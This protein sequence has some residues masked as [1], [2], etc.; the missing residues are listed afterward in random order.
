MA[1]DRKPLKEQ[2][3]DLRAGRT[4]ELDGYAIGL[5]FSQYQA[6]ADTL[7]DITS[8][9]SKISLPFMEK[10]GWEMVVN[11]LEGMTGLQSLNISNPS[12]QEIT[13]PDTL[14]NAIRKM[15]KLQQLNL[16]HIPITTD[17]SH[18]LAAAFKYDVKDLRTIML[19][20]VPQDT[21]SATRLLESL[22]NQPQLG[23]AELEDCRLGDEHLDILLD[24]LDSSP[25]LVQLRIRNNHFSETAQEQIARKLM[26]KRNPNLYWTDMD[27]K[28]DELT[29]F[30]S[31]NRERTLNFK[32][33]L[34]TANWDSQNPPPPEDI[35]TYHRLRT[36]LSYHLPGFDHAGFTAMLDRLLP[37]PPAPPKLDYLLAD[38]KGYTALDNPKTWKQYPDLLDKLAEQGELTTDS[39][40]RASPYGVTLLESAIRFDDAG[41]VIKAVNRVGLSIGAELLISEDGKPTRLMQQ[42]IELN[43]CH[44][45]FTEE[46]WTGQSRQNFRTVLNIIPEEQRTAI[47]NRHA[48]GALVS[49]TEQAGRQ[50]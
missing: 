5:S 35:A 47:S 38:Y 6:I 4:S 50:I 27:A 9:V 28:P 37:M 49:A 19:S 18:T 40:K 25:N 29:A 42:L 22:K 20:G 48:I 16:D 39:L 26:E 24:V 45:L 11:S 7:A 14:I 34:R 10:S 41:K 1:T 36:V 30:I 15:A 31:K 8:S 17:Q 44:A 46:N 21:I 3:E 13:A 32:D 2:L 33:R 12:G 43:E 23:I